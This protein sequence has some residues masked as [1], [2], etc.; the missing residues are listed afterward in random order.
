MSHPL[1]PLFR[2]SAKIVWN[3]TPEN[4]F[5]VIKSRIAK[6]TENNNYDPHFETLFKYDASSARLKAALDQLTV[7]GWKPTAITSRILNFCEERYSVNELLS[8][9][10]SLEYFEKNLHR[11]QL[12]VFTDQGTPLNIKR[13]PFKYIIR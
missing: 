13:K 5:I 8:V 1:S 4:C 9:V 12:K 6:A 10:W 3:D 7:G 2:K 11:K